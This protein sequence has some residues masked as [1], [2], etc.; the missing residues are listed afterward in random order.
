MGFSQEKVDQITSR[1]LA[2]ETYRPTEIEVHYDKITPKLFAE[3]YIGTKD[4]IPTTYEVYCSNG[5]PLFITV[6][7]FNYKDRT[8]GKFINYIQSYDIDWSVLPWYKKLYSNAPI[9]KNLSGIL[10]IASILSKDM[11]LLRVDLFDIDGKV[12]FNELTLSPG[13]FIFSSWNKTGIVE[14]GHR[15]LE[16]I[17]SM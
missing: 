4:K 2:K 17:G 3:E 10:E 6:A 12:Y 11:D 7:D 1:W 9:P 8:I 15:A 13:G 16:V 14:A 5:K